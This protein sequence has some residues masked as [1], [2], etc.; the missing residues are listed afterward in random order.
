[1]DEIKGKST[2]IWLTFFNAYLYKQGLITEMERN[3]MVN[4]IANTQASF[5]KVDNISNKIEK[6]SSL[7]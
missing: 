3:K 1:L 4:K 7:V 6:M 2:Q 5:I